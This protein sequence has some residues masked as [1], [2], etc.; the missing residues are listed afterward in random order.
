[1][2]MGNR[3][4]RKA[5][6]LLPVNEKCVG[7][8]QRGEPCGNYPID[9]AVVCRVHGGSAPQVRRKAQE[10]IAMAQDDA[11]SMLVQFM[12]SDKVP[13]PE[14]RRIAEFLL[15]YETRNEVKLHVAKWEEALDE[16][17]V[18]Y[19]EPGAI[20]GEASDPY[21]NANYPSRPATALRSTP[22]PDGVPRGETPPPRYTESAP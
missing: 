15:T 7:R 14:R 16:V 17:F 19:N 13:F 2:S 1:M 12:S 10:R 18:V 3:K 11:A 22:F 9:G 4:R 20:E 6:G 8:N 5:L 21:E